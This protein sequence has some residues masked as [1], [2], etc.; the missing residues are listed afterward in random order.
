MRINFSSHACAR[1]RQRAH[2]PVSRGK[3]YVTLALETETAVN[4]E[5]VNKYKL[6]NLH[7][8]KN[9]NEEIVAYNHLMFVVKRERN[10][11]TVITVMVIH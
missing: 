7:K 6:K 11:I 1:L 9:D 2:C 10:V 5:Y 3:E 8:R 4:E